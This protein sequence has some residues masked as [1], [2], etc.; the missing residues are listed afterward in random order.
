MHKHVHAP[1]S[2]NLS[3]LL[4]GYIPRSHLLQIHAQMYRLGAH[5]DNLIATRLIGHNESQSALTI[6]HQLQRPNIFPFNAIIRVLAE[7]GLFSNA[8]SLFKSLKRHS[9]YP[10]EFTFSFLLKSC[11][12]SKSPHHV[13][14]LHTH[15]LKTGFDGD[16]FVSNG[17]VNVY[18]KGLKDLVSGRKV[19]DEIPQKGRICCWTSLIAGFAQSGQSEDVLQ[20]FLLMIAENLKPEDDTLVSIL[21]ACSNLQI[22]DTKKWEQIFSVRIHY[23]D[24]NN[25]CRDSVK[26]ILIYLYGKLGNFEKSRETFDGIIDKSKKSLLPWNA[27]IIAYVQNGCPVE[28]LSLFRLMLETSSSRPNHITMVSVLS[29]CAQ[30]GDLNLGSWIHDYIIHNGWKGVLESNKILATALIDMYCKCGNLESAKD[31]FDHII[32][33][34]VISFNAMIMGH[35]M[36]SKGEEALRLFS[37]MRDSNVEPNAATFIGVLCACSHSGLLEAGSNIFSRMTKCFSVSPQLEHYACYIDLLSRCGQLEQALQVVNSIDFKT[38]KFVWGALLG[39]CL[40]HSR[41]DFALDVSR[42]LVEV[43]PESSAGYVM[44]SNALAFDCKWGDVLALRWL[45]GEKG[46]KKQV[47]CSWISID[48]EVHQFVAGFQSH[49]QIEIIFYTLDQ[50]LKE[51]KISS[52]ISHIS[53]KEV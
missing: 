38:N 7:E 23:L 47:G 51:M 37:E 6:F 11:F 34:D 53:W 31:I 27:M 18:A 8:I 4:Q 14:Q 36:N 15:I 24:S 22:V 26:I 49:P 39:G 45:M 40:L 9:L 19:F 30:I 25:L 43:D 50:L 5:Q 33:K 10:N 3:V 13:K 16:L 41:L 32:S 29:A 44:L 35:A 21:S 20:L 1:N 52:L 46:V 12:R 2:A 42:R 28:A 48:G 17:L